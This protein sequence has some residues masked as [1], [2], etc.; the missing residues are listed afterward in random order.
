MVRFLPAAGRPGSEGGRCAWHFRGLRF[1]RPPTPLPSF[2]PVSSSRKWAQSPARPRRA[3]LVGGAPARGARSLS[4]REGTR[5][6][7]S[8]SRGDCAP[9]RC[10]P[11]GGGAGEGSAGKARAGRA[12]RA[13]ATGLPSWRGGRRGR[14]FKCVRPRPGKRGHARARPQV[15][16][17]WGPAAVGAEPG[18]GQGVVAVGGSLRGG[19]RPDLPRPRCPGS[20]QPQSRAGQACPP[21]GTCLL[22][23][24]QH[25]P[26]A[27]A[28]AFH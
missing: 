10:G 7:A 11:E 23:G 19:L 18:L 28:G 5:G 12:R 13:W 9:R 20:P 15:S 17:A 1:P 16:A 8:G 26:G 3:R 2:R 4:T 21:G 24:P 27:R 25:S 22:S 6:A 14:E